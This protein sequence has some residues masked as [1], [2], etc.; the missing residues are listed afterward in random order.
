MSE[1]SLK[2][3]VCYCQKQQ[4]NLAVKGESR[5][6]SLMSLNKDRKPN[7]RKCYDIFVFFWKSLHSKQH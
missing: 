7:L 6:D 2:H 5:S 3:L 4:I 1:M